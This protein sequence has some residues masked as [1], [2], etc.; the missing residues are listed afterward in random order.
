M[1]A[2]SA[3]FQKTYG[4]SKIKYLLGNQDQKNAC[5]V[6]KIR[7]SSDFFV[8]IFNARDHGEICV[9]YTQSN[10]DKNHLGQEFKE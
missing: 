7:V 4:A 1:N 10:S 3:T 5:K 8:V 2:H 9:S 6:K